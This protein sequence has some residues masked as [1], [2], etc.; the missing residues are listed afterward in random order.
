[1][2]EE[3]I[4]LDGRRGMMAQKATDIR[5]M[6]AVVEANEKQLRERQ[7]RSRHN[8]QPC[9]RSRGTTPARRRATY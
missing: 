2:A 7:K 3:T 6:I 1:M 9:R 5:R 8:W 4:K